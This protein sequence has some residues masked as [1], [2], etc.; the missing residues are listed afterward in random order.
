LIAVGGPGSG[1][2]TFVTK[3]LPKYFRVNN[4]TLKT[5]EKCMKVCK[6][7]LVDGKS[8]VIDNTNPTADVRKRYIDIA[9]SLKIPIRAFILMYQKTPAFITTSR[10]KQIY[11]TNIFQTQS[12]P[13]PSI[14]IS[15]T[16]PC[17]Q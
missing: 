5:K 16:I 6:E 12:K 13:Y 15:K 7:L 10:G 2:S 1:N 9:K 8:V 14:V 17:Q 3:F 11:I 4:Y